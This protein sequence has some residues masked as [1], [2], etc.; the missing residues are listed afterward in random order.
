[1]SG[2]TTDDR[3]SAF[4]PAEPPLVLPACLR[5]RSG[6]YSAA[7]LRDGLSEEESSFTHVSG[8][9]WRHDRLADCPQP[10]SRVHET[11]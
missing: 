4:R 2:P 3:A 1:M 10:R 11:R 8:R 7:M 9:A 5:A 6:A